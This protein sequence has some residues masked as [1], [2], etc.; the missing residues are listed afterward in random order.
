MPAKSKSQQQSAAIALKAKEKGTIEDLPKKSAS[1]QIAKSMTKKELEKFAKTKRKNLP[2][3]VDENIIE[4][5]EKELLVQE[6]MIGLDDEPISTQKTKSDRVKKRKNNK[7]KY[8]DLWT[9]SVVVTMDSGVKNPLSNN[10]MGTRVSE[11]KDPNSLD[12]LFENNINEA[13]EFDTSYENYKNEKINEIVNSLLFHYNEYG[14]EPSSWEP[15]VLFQETFKY[16]PDNNN[17]SDKELLKWVQ[18]AINTANKEIGL[19]EETTVRWKKMASIKEQTDDDPTKIV[20]PDQNLDQVILSFIN[21]LDD[22]SSDEEEDNS[23]AGG[24][25]GIEEAVL[26]GVSNGAPSPGHRAKLNQT[27]ELEQ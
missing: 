23:A 10:T 25:E 12:I 15:E 1:Y 16:E 14:H 11:V 3:H 24:D 2:K 9:N 8:K 19:T 26:G 6:E 20:A 21:D 22:D 4:N 27:K 13:E 18:E 17:E 5:L 7:K